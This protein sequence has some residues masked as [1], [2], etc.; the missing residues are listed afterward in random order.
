MATTIFNFPLIHFTWSNKENSFCL[1]GHWGIQ[2]WSHFSK[3]L[4]ICLA[5]TFVWTLKKAPQARRGL[6]SAKKCQLLALKKQYFFIDDKGLSLAFEQIKSVIEL[7]L[8]LQK[9]RV[10]KKKG[11]RSMTC[12]WNELWWRDESLWK[13][14]LFESC[15]FHTKILLLARNEMWETTTSQIALFGCRP[16]KCQVRS[17]SALRETT[18]LWTWGEKIDRRRNNCWLI[19]DGTHIN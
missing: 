18:H 7:L 15:G 6:K 4:V 11:Q 10:K 14:V 3:T 13:H 16:W 19:S 9:W 5:A 8:F 2:N 1:S 17:S 12:I